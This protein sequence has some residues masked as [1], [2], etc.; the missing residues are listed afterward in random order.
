MLKTCA[1]LSLLFLCL[2]A[3]TQSTWEVYGGAKYN[4]TNVTQNPPGPVQGLTYFIV[5]SDLR[6][7]RT[8]PIYTHTLGLRYTYVVRDWLFPSL[9]LQSTGKGFVFGA[10]RPR[11]TW[12]LIYQQYIQLGAQLYVSVP[13]GPE[14]LKKLRIGGGLSYNFLINNPAQIPLAE[15]TENF[16]HDHAQMERSYSLGLQYQLYPRWFIQAYVERGITPYGRYTLESGALKFEF[17]N[18]AFGIRIG[19]RINAKK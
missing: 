4:I 18:Q 9:D 15:V 7:S 8:S 5:P 3:F 13:E 1:F 14:W 2:S 6:S 12:V 16:G 17:Q 19:Y 10:T 11:E